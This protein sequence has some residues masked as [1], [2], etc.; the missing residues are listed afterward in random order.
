MLPK[1][2]AVFYLK[3]DYFCHMKSTNFVKAS[4]LVL[5]V[6]LTFSACNYK[7]KNV[8]EM[9][10]NEPVTE[11]NGYHE[12]E[13]LTGFFQYYADAPSFKLCGDTLVFPV[14]MDSNYLVL[15]R[16]YTDANLNGAPV[17]VELKGYFQTDKNMEDKEVKTLFV[18]SLEVLD[19]KG[20][21]LP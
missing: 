7:T 12:P 2:Y 10:E 21:C 13:A 18:E 8:E 20:T 19:V 11:D 17:Y 3:M 16:A 5:A 14:K 9:I 1:E 4:T 15:E 6:S